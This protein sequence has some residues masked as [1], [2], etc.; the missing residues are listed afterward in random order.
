MWCHDKK[1][2]SIS[3]NIWTFHSAFCVCCEQGSA[4]CGLLVS[5]LES[6]DISPSQ[7]LCQY[8]RHQPQ[9]VQTGQ[10]DGLECG[11]ILW[12]WSTHQ[13]DKVPQPTPDPPQQ[14]QYQ[15]RKRGRI[16]ELVRIERIACHGRTLLG[17]PDVR[18][19]DAGEAVVGTA[20]PLPIL[21]KN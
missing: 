21:K 11:K 19:I 9:R 10:G 15:A 6:R 4:A 5:Q 7:E 3:P 8:I 14:Y 1:F 16:F 12:Y 13:R 2:D 17:D 18:T 20:A